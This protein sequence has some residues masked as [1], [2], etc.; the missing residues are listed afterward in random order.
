MVDFF[1]NKSAFCI[2][3][4]KFC[5]QKLIL[6]NKPQEIFSGLNNVTTSPCKSMKFLTI[7]SIFYSICF[8]GNVSNLL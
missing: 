2:R 3:D 8:S 4:F 5:M 1:F 7:S 6:K